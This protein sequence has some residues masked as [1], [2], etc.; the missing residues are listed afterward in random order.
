[1]SL[2]PQ[3]PTYSNSDK[4]YVHIRCLIANI[5]KPRNVSRPPSA[6]IDKGAPLEVVRES[7]T[8]SD[9]ERSGSISDRSDDRLSLDELAPTQRAK[10]NSFAGSMLTPPP[11]HQ[12]K[13][14]PS[15]LH[16]GGA[17]APGPMSAGPH[18]TVPKFT[19]TAPPGEQHRRLSH[20]FAAFHGFAL[21]RHSNTVCARMICKCE[22]VFVLFYLNSSEC[23]LINNSMSEDNLKNCF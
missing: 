12:K 17:A 5:H 14:R 8:S 4:E 19:L 2:P 9:T 21:R 10:S 3:L 1:M 23:V 7:P 13:R 16:I 22:R 18:F 15:F 20:G 6:S 11:L